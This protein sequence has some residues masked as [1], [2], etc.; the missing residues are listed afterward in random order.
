MAYRR[1]DAV[2]P[3]ALRT[4]VTHTWRCPDCRTRRKDYG[5]FT[6]HLRDSGHKICRCGRYPY[7]HRPGSPLCVSN[8]MSD[9]RRAEQFGEITKDELEEIEVDCAW[10]KRGRPFMKWRD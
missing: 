3:P 8:P 9:V 6:Q 7:S 1:G 2:L 10:S 4:V 5:L